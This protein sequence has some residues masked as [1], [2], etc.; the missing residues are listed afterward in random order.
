MLDMCCM[1]INVSSW[2]SLV[3]PPDVSHE[4]LKF[5]P[6]TFFLF[7]QSTVLSSHAVDGHQM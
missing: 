5:Y 3:K 2:L 7:Y 4:V 1:S 6:S